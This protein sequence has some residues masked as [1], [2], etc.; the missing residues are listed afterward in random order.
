M[1]QEG[2]HNIALSYKQRREH[3]FGPTTRHKRTIQKVQ[4]NTESIT[5]GLTKLPPLPPKVPTQISL[6]LSK[7]SKS[8]K[9]LHSDRNTNVATTQFQRTRSKRDMMPD[10]NDDKTR[11]VMEHKSTRRES[12]PSYFLSAI[13]DPDFTAPEGMDG[14]CQVPMLP[15]NRDLALEELVSF[16]RPI[17]DVR[18]IWGLY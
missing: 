2:F 13:P 16:T 3:A 17:G 11:S 9:T 4:S 8:V 14:T 15:M 5:S 10:K 1:A 18:S 6:S 12:M 7:D